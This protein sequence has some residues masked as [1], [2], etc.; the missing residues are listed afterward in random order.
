MSVRSFF[1]FF[2]EREK[3]SKEERSR[4][5]DERVKARLNKENE[6]PTVTRHS[7]LI[8]YTIVKGNPPL[9]AEKEVSTFLNSFISKKLGVISIK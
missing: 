9:L 5:R 2:F 7:K 3:G 1:F 8:Q 4:G 6:K